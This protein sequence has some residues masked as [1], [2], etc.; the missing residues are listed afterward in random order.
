[1]HFSSVSFVSTFSIDVQRHSCCRRTFSHWTLKFPL[2]HFWRKSYT[3]WHGHTPYRFYR[4][5]QA[6]WIN[7]NYMREC[8]EHIP[9]FNELIFACA[10]CTISS[11]NVFA[12]A[13]MAERAEDKW[14]IKHKKL[15]GQQIWN[16]QK[17]KTIRVAAVSTELKNNQLNLLIFRA[18]ALLWNY[19]IA[20]QN[21]SQTRVTRFQIYL[22]MYLSNAYKLFPIVSS[23]VEIPRQT[24]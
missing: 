15:I 13:F 20:V 5:W 9:S 18:V 3:V 14:K 12:F 7:D 10:H 2:L 23:F 21:R 6:T 8:N 11:S 17:M 24:E 22:Y 19:L 1:M 4:L 16:R